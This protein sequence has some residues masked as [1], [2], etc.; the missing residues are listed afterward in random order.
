MLAALW[1]A[2]DPSADSGSLEGEKH[3]I[4]TQG[5][6]GPWVW[7]HNFCYI[8]RP[9]CYNI[10]I[11]VR[12]SPAPAINTEVAAEVKGD[13]FWGALCCYEEQLPRRSQNSA[14]ER[15]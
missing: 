4:F 13:R 2:L 6:G 14:A 15:A 11:L 12:S 5:N 8:N 10:R 1:S 9:I 3:L 7:C